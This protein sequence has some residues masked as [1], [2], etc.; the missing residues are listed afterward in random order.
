MSSTNAVEV[1]IQATSPLLQSNPLSPH[2]G[3]VAGAAAGAAGAV[4][5]GVA[6]APGAGGLSCANGGLATAAKAALDPGSA[7]RASTVLMSVIPY[8]AAAS[9]SPVGMRMPCPRAT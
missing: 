9:V 5:A 8:S 1:S 4:A 7:N 2:F 6:S 3:G